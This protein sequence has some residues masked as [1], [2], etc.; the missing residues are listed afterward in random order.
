VKLETRILRTYHT[1]A[2][3]GASPNLERPSHRVFNY[4]TEQ[5]YRVIPVNPT[6]KDVMGKT[7]YPDL[8]S[9]PEKVEVVD[10]FR[11]SEEVMPIVGEAIKIGA[12]AVWMQEGVINEAAAARGRDA[13]LLV[14]MDRCMRREHLRLMRQRRHN[15][16]RG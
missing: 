12:K 4:L 3:V 13:G 8:S 11:N 5:G 9:I 7:S 14:V 6:I 10:I 2:M 15:K 16:R 1:V